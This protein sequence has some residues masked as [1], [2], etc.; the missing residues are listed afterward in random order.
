MKKRILTLALLLS[1]GVSNIFANNEEGIS[2]KA[3][4]AFKKEFSQAKDVK[5]ETGKEFVKATVRILF[6]S[7]RV[8]GNNQEYH[9]YS[10]T[11]E[12]FI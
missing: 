10:V 8:T 5:W 4:S 7:R 1:L 2:Q 12:P 11:N 6:S 9:I 3:T